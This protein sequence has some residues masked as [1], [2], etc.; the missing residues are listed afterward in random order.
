MTLT[1]RRRWAGLVDV[2][3]ALLG[4]QLTGDWRIDLARAAA[5]AC[6]PLELPPPGPHTGGLLRRGDS[7]T[8]VIPVDH[9]TIPPTMVEM[10]REYDEGRGRETFTFESRLDLTATRPSRTGRF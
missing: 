2:C 8:I 9:G 10:F 4:R 1:E 6:A 3:L 7:R 5:K